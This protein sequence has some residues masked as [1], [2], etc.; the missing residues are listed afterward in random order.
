MP[1]TNVELFDNGNKMECDIE[2]ENGF[3]NF[4]VQD[5]TGVKR[6]LCAVEWNNDLMWSIY[7]E[8]TRG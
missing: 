2:V 5:G 7:R 3:I 6:K 4:Y 8:E 1:K